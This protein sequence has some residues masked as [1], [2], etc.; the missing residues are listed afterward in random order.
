L[1]L[2]Y[3]DLV[4]RAGRLGAEAERYMRQEPSATTLFRKISDR[5]L[6]EEQLRGL[7]DQVDALSPDEGDPR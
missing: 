2:D 5:R 4:A 3:A 7:I 1:D 6:S